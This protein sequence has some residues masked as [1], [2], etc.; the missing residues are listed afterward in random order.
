MEIPRVVPS[1]P[2][3][4]SVSVS[5]DEGIVLTAAMFLTSW[6]SGIVLIA[7]VSGIVLI[8]LGLGIRNRSHDIHRSQAHW[9]TGSFSPHWLLESCSACQSVCVCV[10]QSE[11]TA[12]NFFREN[13]K[14]W[15][16]NA[17]G[18]GSDLKHTFQ[19]FATFS[20]K[21][22]PSNFWGKKNRA[23]QNLDVVGR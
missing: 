5:L 2:V 15:E 22:Y 14:G 20:L 3:S 19:C 18:E 16:K 21:P 7:L 9:C 1:L 23:T 4:K 10:K 17:N 13:L 6:G 12:A 8:A 11:T